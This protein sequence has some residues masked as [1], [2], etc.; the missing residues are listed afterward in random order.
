MESLLSI[1]NIAQF[2]PYV[3]LAFHFFGLSHFYGRAVISG[4]NLS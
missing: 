1:L 4:D 3:K 2:T